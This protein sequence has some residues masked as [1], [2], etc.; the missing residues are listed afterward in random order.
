MVKVQCVHAMF[1]YEDIDKE[2]LLQTVD[3]SAPGSSGPDADMLCMTPTPPK[4]TWLL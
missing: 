1:S 2:L 4:L 3:Y